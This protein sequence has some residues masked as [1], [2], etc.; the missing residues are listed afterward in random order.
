MKFEQWKPH[1]EITGTFKEENIESAVQTK[2]SN[3]LSQ[4]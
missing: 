3:A 2:S 4:L 1:K